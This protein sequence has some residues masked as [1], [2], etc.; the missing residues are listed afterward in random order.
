MVVLT[1]E[2]IINKIID[3][4]SLSLEEI[5]KKIKQKLEQL[6]GLV[7]EEGAAHIIANELGVELIPSTEN[8]LEISKLLEGLRNVEI[9]AKVVRKFDIKEFNSAKASGKLASFIIAD[10]TGKIRATLW[11]TKVDDYFDKVNEGDTITIKNAYVR[12]NNFNDS[13]D[14]N[15]GDNAEIIINPEGVKIDVEASSSNVLKKK[16]EEINPD[17]FQVEVLATIVQLS[18]IR[19]WNVCPECNKK[20]KV[21]GDKYFCSE[22]GEISED[23]VDLSYVLNCYLDDGSASIRTV[24]WKEQTQKLLSENHETI[25]KYKESP[26]LFE[27]FKSDLL[28][29]MIKVIGKVNKNN[30]FD[31]VELIADTIIKNPDPEEEIKKIPDTKEKAP[32]QKEKPEKLKEEPKT[33]KE[34]PSLDDIEEINIDDE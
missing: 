6:T 33:N 27:P 20:L 34:I 7:S 15:L 26:D 3:T 10:K 19:F 17:D 31:K 1:K 8:A 9:N 14:I 22:H 23:K 13:L 24:F 30:V 29:D 11:N 5:N 12:R 18:D 25:V 4:T 2:Q 21:E 28:G 32:E 16:I